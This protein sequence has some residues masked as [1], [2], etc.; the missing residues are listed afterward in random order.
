MINGAVMP[1]TVRASARRLP[2]TVSSAAAGRPSCA[3]AD[4][5]AVDLCAMER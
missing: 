3:C 1:P 4:L 2:N 5:G